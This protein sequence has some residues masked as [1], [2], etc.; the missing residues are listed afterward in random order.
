MSPTS[1]P[2]RPWSGTGR[3]RSL[4]AELESAFL[5]LAT[6]P[7]PLGVQGRTVCTNWPDRL[8]P[9]DELRARLLH[10]AC[11]Y[12]TR[13]RALNVVLHLARTE[14]DPWL[15]ALVGLLLPGLRR[16]VRTLL[17]ANPD[18]AADLQAEILTGLLAA[19]KAGPAVRVRPGSELIWSAR[20]AADRLLHI[21]RAERADTELD[22]AAPPSA[23][24]AGHPD[25]VLARAVAAG[26]LSAD[27][28]ELIAA[29][30]LGQLSLHAAA[31]LRAI[32]YTA[33]HHRRSRAEQALIRWLAADGC[34]AARS[35]GAEKKMWSEFGETPPQNPGSFGG[36]RPRL[37]RG[38]T[39]DPG[40]ATIPTRPT[41]A[42]R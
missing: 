8:I 39:G 13:D 15:S 1:I 26:V 32:S 18:L 33:A 2:A 38:T 37:G 42:R 27:D 10:P 40:C 29:T 22:M 11:S 30:R 5:L 23:G 20:R 31:E 25:F 14:G 24:P 35:A 36:G 16:S 34:E 4:F 21:E 17:A 3:D 41:I 19:I 9:A 7:T 28:A 12:T 6:G